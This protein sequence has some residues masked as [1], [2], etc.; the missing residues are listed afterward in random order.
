MIIAVTD[1]GL[2]VIIT[3][4]SSNLSS[5]LSTAMTFHFMQILWK[6]HAGISRNDIKKLVSFVAW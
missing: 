6:F 3:V 1:I 4:L 5:P 2:S